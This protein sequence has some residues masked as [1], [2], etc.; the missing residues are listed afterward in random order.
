MQRANIA[1]WFLKEQ[2][3]QVVHSTATIDRV[4]L[5]VLVVH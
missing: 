3:A 1:F 4:S 5:G 2:V